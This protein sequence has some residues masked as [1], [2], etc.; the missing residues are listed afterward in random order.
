MGSFEDDAKRIAQDLGRAHFDPHGQPKNPALNVKQRA[1]RDVTELLGVA[2]GLLADGVI[3][4]EEANYLRAWG[5]NHPD[6]LRQWPASLI[7]SRLTQMFADG[8]I[9]DL[10]RRELRDILE[11]VVGGEISVALGYDG[12][13]SELPLDVPPP[14]VCWDGEVYV[15]TGKF[16]Y[17]TRQQCQMDVMERGAQVE[18]DVTKR[19]TFLVL[20]TFSSRDWKH[21]SFGRKIEHAVRLRSGGFPIRIV[22]EDHWANALNRLGV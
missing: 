9:D 19:T 1:E 13:T 6:A 2:K 7:F 8:Q 17:G 20:G 16:A 10:E 15:F 22:G 3:V 4:E 11:Q 21:T 14:L 12:V 5:L 18:D